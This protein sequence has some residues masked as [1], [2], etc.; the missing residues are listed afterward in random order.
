[1]IELVMQRQ[2]REVQLAIFT[3]LF[4][5][6]KSIDLPWEAKY[7][8]FER[9]ILDSK[10]IDH[11]PIVEVTRDA[12]Q[13]IVN[14]GFS[15]YNKEVVRGHITDRKDR[16]EILFTRN[17]KSNEEA[18]EYFLK[19]E[20]VALITRSENSGNKGPKDWSKRYSIPLGIF[21]YRSGFSAKYSDEALFYLRTLAQ[22][23]KIYVKY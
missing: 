20:Q 22:Q 18:F 6:F 15:K 8:G 10:K 9:I 23:E 19:H 16:A 13:C 2:P 3:N 4:E 21:P 1:M 7:T 14:N 12:L 17:F 11:W 5:A